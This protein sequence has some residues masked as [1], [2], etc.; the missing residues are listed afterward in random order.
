VDA[1][2][3]EQVRKCSKRHNRCARDRDPTVVCD[4]RIK[5]GK[6]LRC[7]KKAV[8]WVTGCVQQRPRCGVLWRIDVE[9]VDQNIRIENSRFN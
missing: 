8:G 9:G 5:L 7:H 3:G 1:G 2:V 6:D 4:Y